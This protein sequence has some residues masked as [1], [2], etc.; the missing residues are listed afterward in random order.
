MRATQAHSSPPPTATE[1]GLERAAQLLLSLPQSVSPTTSPANISDASAKFV[2]HICTLN[3][4]PLSSLL[5]R[6]PLLRRC[7]PLLREALGATCSPPRLLHLA[8]DVAERRLPATARRRPSSGNE[9]VEAEGDLQ[10]DNTPQDREAEVTNLAVEN[11]GK[12]RFIPNPLQIFLSR[13]HNVES[14]NV[15]ALPVGVLPW[16]VHVPGGWTSHWESDQPLQ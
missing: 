6:L 8:Q 1:R 7:S 9:Q 15:T 11:Q 16:D 2:L 5:R 4:T 14:N 13:D 10:Q 12:P 3:G